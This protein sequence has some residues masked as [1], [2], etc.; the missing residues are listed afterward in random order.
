M[1]TAIQTAPATTVDPTINDGDNSDP[2]PEC[3]TIPP[4][5]DPGPVKG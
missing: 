5:G 3:C 1:N 2:N 4:D